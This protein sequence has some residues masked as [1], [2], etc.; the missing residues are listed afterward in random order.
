MGSVP[1]SGLVR[2]AGVVGDGSLVG[3]AA[4][5][6]GVH[7]ADGWTGLARPWGGDGRVPSLHALRQLGQCDG[8][9]LTR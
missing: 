4:W 2:A 7:D 6:P 1:A 8:G 3:A 9:L 5:F